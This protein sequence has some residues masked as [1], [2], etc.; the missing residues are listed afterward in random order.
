MLPDQSTVLWRARR[1]T[2]ET[3]CFVRLVPYGIEVDLTRNGRVVLT[4]VFE[5]DGEALGWSQGKLAIRQREGWTL[6]PE[7][8]VERPVA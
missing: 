4:R 8:T 1:D 5:T 2:E 3:A 6:V 7:T